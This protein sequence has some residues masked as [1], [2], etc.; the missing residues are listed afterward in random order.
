[1]QLLPGRRRAAVSHG[2]TQG[3]S[4]SHPTLHPS[5]LSQYY[6]AS[7]TTHYYR[8]T[9][10]EP[11]LRFPSEENCAAESRK[12]CCNGVSSRCVRPTAFTPSQIRS[13]RKH[14][15]SRN[16]RKSLPIT[17]WESGHP[18]ANYLVLITELSQFSRRV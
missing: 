9:R 12:S 18:T 10:L 17:A 4:V 16:A 7:A 6:S 1:M 2:Q 14:G 5:R 13:F 3:L 15:K 11:T 8:R